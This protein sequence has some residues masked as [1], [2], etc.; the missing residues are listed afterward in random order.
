LFEVFGISENSLP[1]EK[2]SCSG[3][4]IIVGGG[5]CVWEDLSRIHWESYDIMCV[6]DIYMHFPGDVDHYYSNDHH[7]MPK[8]VEAR[9]QLL[10]R[11]YPK[12]T[13]FHTNRFGSDGI[14]KWPWTGH[15]T[16]GLNA[17]YTGL[18]LGY[19][20]IILAGIPLDNGGHYFDP[21][22]SENTGSWGNRKFSHFVEE[23]PVKAGE[24]KYWKN[25]KDN[26]FQGKVTSLS[27]RSKD[28]LG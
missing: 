14:V 15:G 18:A 11:A 6:N 23:I 20:K 25:A 1:K 7:W 2:N 22:P 5:W 21:R 9:R 19:D 3:E 4:L 24:L 28:L 16:S 26:V 12:T 13:K 10:S 27:G 8:W 17:I